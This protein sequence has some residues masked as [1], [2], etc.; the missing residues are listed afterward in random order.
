MFVFSFWFWESAFGFGCRLYMSRRDE[1]TDD[2]DQKGGNGAT[3]LFSHRPVETFGFG[4]LLLLLLLCVGCWSF[5]RLAPDRLLVSSSSCFF[6]SKIFRRNC[7]KKPAISRRVIMTFAPV[8][9]IIFGFQGRKGKEKE[10]E[11][12]SYSSGRFISST[13]KAL[14]R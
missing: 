9:F 11:K 6:S 12:K 1:P 5:P 4:F 13:N 14:A 7:N 8:S 2:D 10:K 3:A